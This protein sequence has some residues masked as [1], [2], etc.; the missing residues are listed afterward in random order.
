MKKELIIEEKIEGLIITIRGL[1]V[2][3]DSDLASL[4]GV[5]TKQFNRAVK[6]NFDRFPSDFMFQLTIEEFESLR[7]QFGTSKKNQNLISQTVISKGKGGRRYLPYAFTE[8][9]VAMLSSVLN[10]ERAI[11]VNIEIMR[12][13][14]KLRQII[15]TH[16]DLLHRLNALQERYDKYFKVIFDALDQMM[17]TQEDKREHGPMGFEIRK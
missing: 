1:K 6:R 15:S 17:N 16:E 3:L 2:I 10:S 8:Y 13:F 14:G 12:I 11:K 7:C 5:D 9:G 4:Y